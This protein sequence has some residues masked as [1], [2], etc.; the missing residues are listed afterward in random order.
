M[1]TTEKKIEY[2]KSK[3]SH[4]MPQLGKLLHHLIG[5]DQGGAAINDALLR[6]AGA[7][8][9]QVDRAGLVQVEAE[10]HQVLILDVVTATDH[11]HDRFLKRIF[12]ARDRGIIYR[13][14]TLLAQNL[15]IEVEEAFLILARTNLK[16]TRQKSSMIH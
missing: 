8:A 16:R 3:V 7:G 15:G 11:E 14:P 6:H 2:L 12:G 10:V 13:S 1:G 4:F 9:N 5:V